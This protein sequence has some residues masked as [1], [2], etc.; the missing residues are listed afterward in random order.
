MCRGSRGSRVTRAR[1]LLAHAMA[2]LPCALGGLVLW[3][4]STW[5]GS[6]PKDRWVDRGYKA[7]EW[8][9]RRGKGGIEGG[10]EGGGCT[11]KQAIG[12]KIV[13][14]IHMIYPSARESMSVTPTMVY[15]LEEGAREERR[16]RGREEEPKR[17]V[18][19]G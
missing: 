1:R 12:S 16:K 14:A 19:A 4:V 11:F 13:Y 7:R 8:G 18:A 9:E 6:Q 17:K 15:I 2:G 3:A 5:L 10:G